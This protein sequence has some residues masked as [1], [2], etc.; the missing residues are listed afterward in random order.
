MKVDQRTVWQTSSAFPGPVTPRTSLVL[1]I[2][3]SSALSRQPDVS[4]ADGGSDALGGGPRHWLVLSRPTR[5][6][7]V[8]DRPNLVKME[9]ESTEMIRE[10]PIK[11]NSD[12]ES[13]PVEW[14]MVTRS[15]PGGGIPRFM[16]ERGTPGSIVADV[17]KFLN[18]ATSKGE[19]ELGQ[20]G[21][22]DAVDAVV[23]QQNQQLHRTEHE[24]VA[25][26]DSA[27]SAAVSTQQLPD[28]DIRPPGVEHHGY[29]DRFS[30]AVGSAVSGYLPVFQQQ[31][32]VCS[33]DQLNKEESS[34][35]ISD[36]SDS[37]FRSALHHQRTSELGQGHGLGA[38]ND[39]DASLP[40]SSTTGEDKHS[41]NT[42]KELDKLLHKRA[43]LDEKAR[44]ERDTFAH[45]AA[46]ANEKDEKE[47]IRM[48]D[49]HEKQRKKQE[50][51]YNRELA[52]LDERRI[53]EERR[54]E[55]RRKKT[56]EK[57]TLKRLKQEVSEWK[58]RCQVA[59]EE[60]DLLRKQVENLQRE[61]INNVAQ[62]PEDEAKSI[63]NSSKN[64]SRASSL[65]PE[66]AK[67]GKS[68]TSGQ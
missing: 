47:R 56:E 8:P 67:S 22:E 24:P 48:M 49:K 38:F 58:N 9:Y 63:L 51:R 36:S 59:E 46:Q 34:S 43:A 35:D 45:K 10:I 12:P 1:L 42:S 62:L 18:W 26:E 11:G 52:K 44:K 50:E 15:D 20:D 39:S 29:Y 27:R 21:H 19:A 31:S 54:E 3:S 41:R 66:S 57:D 16:V 33:T 5:H 17:T 23:E 4:D 7:D 61:N 53:K 60:A 25:V 65:K 40:R 2:S 64:R 6:A 32:A 68:A 55:A 13:N 14:T 30:E 28:S 37:T